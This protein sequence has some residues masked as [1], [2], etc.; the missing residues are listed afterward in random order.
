VWEVGVAD[1]WGFSTMKHGLVRLAA[2]GSL[3]LAAVMALGW[4]PAQAAPSEAAP[5]ET[6]YSL[7]GCG[8]PAVDAV[9]DTAVHDAVYAT[10]PAVTGVE[11]L[12][13]RQVP[14]SEWSYSREVSPGYSILSWTRTT[15]LMETEYARTVVDEPFVPAVPGTPE[16]G[17]TENRVVR[18]AVLEHEFVHQKSGDTRWEGAGW[19]AGDGGKGW[20]PTGE[21]REVVPA[22]TEEVWVVDQPATPGSPEVPEVSHVEKTWL[23]S[24]A[25][26]AEGWLATGEPRAAGTDVETATLPESEIPDG[27]GWV[28]GGVVDVVAPVIDVVW[29]PEGEPGPA[30]YA[31]T[32]ASRPAGT[33]TETT[34][35]RSAAAPEGDG[36]SPVP[37]SDVVIVLVPEQTVLVTEA[38]TE[39]VLVSPAVPATPPCDPPDVD[40]PDV[41]PPDGET[42]DTETTDGGIGGP[43]TS[44]SDTSGS[45]TSG[46]DTS[47]S[48]TSG[49]AVSGNQVEA[50][51]GQEVAGAVLPE[52]GAPATAWLAG[53]GLGSV[54][55]GGALVVRRRDEG[56]S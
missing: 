51:S 1:V 38:W 47:G 55:V 2:P 9:Y 25:T 18:E 50:N 33:R 16:I 14:V 12:W 46:S 35:V 10:V 30:G 34:D 54:L 4:S 13:T 44:G 3:A 29:V 5:P 11:S 20:S 8:Q 32:G 19:N 23:P 21:T 31:S 7:P 45:D 41:D 28:L 40:P 43:D 6:A 48:D 53:L 42:P 22:V 26:P 49:G 52:A 36:W 39:Q 17:H 56:V 24:G 37:D 15:T 27:D